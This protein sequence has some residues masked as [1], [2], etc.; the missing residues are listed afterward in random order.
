MD[1]SRQKAISTEE[2]EPVLIDATTPNEERTPP[3]EMSSAPDGGWGWVVVFASF[4]ISWNIG[5]MLIAFS[6]LYV[7]FTYYFQSEKGVTG[8]IGSFYL[9]VGTYFGM[10]IGSLSNK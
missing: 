6:L 7:E 3:Q 1:K 10:S 9:A 4:L 8:W 2:L 5:C